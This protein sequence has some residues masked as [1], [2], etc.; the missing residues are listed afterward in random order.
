M[1][2]LIPTDKKM[3]NIQQCNC[4]LFDKNTQGIRTS[5]NIIFSLLGD[6]GGILAPESWISTIALEKRNLID[7][8]QYDIHQNVQ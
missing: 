6:L 3:T 4:F 1:P 8:R 2:I 7:F 5:Q